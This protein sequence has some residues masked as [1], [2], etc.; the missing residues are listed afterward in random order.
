MVPGISASSDIPH[1]MTTYLGVYEN[2]KITCEIFRSFISHLQICMAFFK[3]L[4]VSSIG[5]GSSPSSG[6]KEK[7]LLSHLSSTHIYCVSIIWQV[8]R[9]IKNIGEHEYQSRKYID[10]SLIVSQLT[11]NLPTQ[12]STHLLCHSFYRSEVRA[13]LQVCNYCISFLYSVIW[14]L[15][16]RGEGDLLPGSVWC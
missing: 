8:L 13:T 4:S 15:R 5:K 14:G 6:L 16:G 1:I 9:F 2:N 7:K 11:T 3:R 10:P 12:N